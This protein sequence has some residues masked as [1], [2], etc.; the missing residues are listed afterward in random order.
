MPLGTAIR[1]L[2]KGDWEKA[3]AI[4]QQDESKL[5]CWAHGIVH[6]VEGDLG[7]ARYWYR[8]AGR[9]FPKDRD[10]D[11]EVAELT[12]A[13]KLVQVNQS[14]DSRVQRHRSLRSPSGNRE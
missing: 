13:L 5:G 3:H 7:N 6:M 11:R 12:T 8:R 2:K 1:H 10:V 14:L 4:V 9:P